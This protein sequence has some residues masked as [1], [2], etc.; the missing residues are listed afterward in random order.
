MEPFNNRIY[1]FKA[2]KR[3]YFVD[4]FKYL[5]WHKYARNGVKVFD[6]PG[7]HATMLHQP[8][9]SEFGKKLQEALN[10]C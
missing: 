2:E 8:N 6:V 3:V 1:L 7:D 10:N 4:D 5:S 9:V